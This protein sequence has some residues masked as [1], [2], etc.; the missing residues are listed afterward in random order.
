MGLQQQLQDDLVAA[1]KARD[2]QKK[3]AIRIIMGEFGRQ[4]TKELSDDQVIAI[5]K[6]LIKSERE[7]LAA[8]GE[9]DSSPYI[10]LLEGYLPRQASE[11]E[12][13]DWIEANIDF[14]AFGHCMQAMKPTMA[15]FGASADGN[16]VKKVLQRFA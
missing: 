4:D 13:F 5:L 3:E 2:A 15:H 9:G 8:K 14:S 11:Q 6:K 16:T 10:A 1:I 7:L 12:I